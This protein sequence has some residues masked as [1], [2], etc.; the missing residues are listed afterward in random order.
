MAAIGHCKVDHLIVDSGA[1]IRNIEIKDIGQK[2]YSLHEVVNEI[3]DKATRQRLQVLPYDITFKEP[4][5]ESYHAVV[6][7][8]K[9]TGDFVSLSPV[10]LRVLALAYQLE[11]ENVGTEHIRH[12]PVRKVEVWQ[13]KRNFENPAQIAGFYLGPKETSQKSS[14]SETSS[15]MGSESGQSKGDNGEDSKDTLVDDNKPEVELGGQEDEFDKAK[16]DGDENEGKEVVENKQEKDEGQNEDKDQ[17]VKEDKDE[18]NNENKDDEN[19][20]NKGNANNH[21]D[22]K[23]KTEDCDKEKTRDD[24][25]LKSCDDSHGNIQ[26]ECD[27]DEEDE[28]D[29]DGCWVTPDNI[30]AVLMQSNLLDVKPVQ[31]VPVACLTTDFAMQNVLLQMGLN[32]LSADGMLIKR[33]KSYVLRCYGCF[34]VVTDM[35]RVVCPKCGYSTLK[36]VSM[37]VNDDGS[38]QYYLSNRKPT[39][40]RALQHP[41]PT[42]K[43]GKHANQ[44][45]KHSQAKYDVFNLDNITLDS[46]FAINDFNRRS[47]NH[48]AKG[49]NRSRR[50]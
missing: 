26:D 36:K 8:S 15:M 4:T 11:K 22:G 49:Q 13:T 31:V 28:D 47:A 10:D 21:D 24:S 7:F 16:Q 3:R 44:Q 29:D 33:A 17:E 9:K 27:D 23:N 39:K 12:E 43:E 1:F 2:I 19:D 25:Q 46:P 34:K 45:N 40:T 37:T 32:V 50:K 38:V 42:P 48:H 35:T 18:G 14:K 6:E 41:R 5:P 30:A 20:K